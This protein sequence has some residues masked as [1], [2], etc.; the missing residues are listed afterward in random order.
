VRETAA[1]SAPSQVLDDAVL[2]TSELVSNAVRHAGHTSDDDPIE[3]TVSVDARTL[4]V[5]VRD[6]GP[7]FDPKAPLVRSEEGGWGLS[8]VRRLSSH[9][10]V[11]SADDGTDVWFEIDLSENGTGTGT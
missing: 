5:S 4:R 11:T 8:L 3:L 9:W 7:G 1:R 6:L 2:L 10:G